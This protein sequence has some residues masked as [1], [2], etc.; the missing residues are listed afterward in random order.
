MWETTKIRRRKK[1]KEKE[2]KEGK[3]GGG[4]RGMMIAERFVFIHSQT[5]F[6]ESELE[7]EF[8]GRR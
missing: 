5:L 4:R 7:E 3:G 8:G 6:R 1:K 2:E